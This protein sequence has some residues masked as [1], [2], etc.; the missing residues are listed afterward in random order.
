[1][2]LIRLALIAASAALSMSASAAGIADK[3]EQLGEMTYLKVSEMRVAKRDGLLAVQVEVSNTDASNQQ[4]Y[5]R[6]KWLD[7]SGFSVWGEEAWKPV[8][9]YGKQKKM[10]NEVAPTPRA[11]DFRMEVQSPNNS[12][13]NISS[14]SSNGGGSN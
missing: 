5:Y 6:F 8:L 14:P 7:E 2:K 9:I 11:S 12:T 13:N 10:I 1:M 4:L 3:L